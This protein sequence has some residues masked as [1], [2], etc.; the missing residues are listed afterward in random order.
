VVAYFIL[1]GA[2]TYWIYMV[3]KGAVFSGEKD[4]VKV[5]NCVELPTTPG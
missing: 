4:G 2:F 3:E 5:I 1:N